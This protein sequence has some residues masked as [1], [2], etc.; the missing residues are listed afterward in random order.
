MSGRVRSGQRDAEDEAK[1]AYWP[2]L[3]HAG[4]SHVVAAQTTSSAGAV[5]LE[6]IEGQTSWHIERTL[7]YNTKTT[8]ETRQCMI[9][10]VICDI[11]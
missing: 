8:L 9:F 6:A 2:V 10:R 5:H 11:E 7:L 4:L 1:A 3:F